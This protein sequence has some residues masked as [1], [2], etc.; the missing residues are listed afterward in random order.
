MGTDSTIEAVIRRTKEQVGQYNLFTGELEPIAA[1]N[2]EAA[3][4]GW[5]FD[6]VLGLVLP[7][8]P[9]GREIVIDEGVLVRF[10]RWPDSPIRQARDSGE[11]E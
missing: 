5:L 7:E 4:P 1:G 6:P 9:A 2:G 8:N 11:G 10:P 3:K